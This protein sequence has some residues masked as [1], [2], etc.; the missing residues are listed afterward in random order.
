MGSCMAG[1]AGHDCA[2]PW[3]VEGPALQDTGQGD[4]A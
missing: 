4:Q 3:T 1:V 2:A